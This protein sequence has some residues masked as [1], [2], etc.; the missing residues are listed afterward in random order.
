MVLTVELRE[1]LQLRLNDEPPTENLMEHFGAL[2]KFYDKAEA[3]GKLFIYSER[4]ISRCSAAAVAI[5]M[6]K[7]RSDYA[8]TLALVRSKRPTSLPN[9]NFAHQVCVSHAF[10]TCI[11]FL[12]LLF[13]FLVLND[14][15]SCH[16]FRCVFFVFVWFF[17]CKYG[18]TL[19][20]SPRLQITLQTINATAVR[21]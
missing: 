5:L 4:G 21:R 14:V 8:Q 3:L 20:T 2:F 1:Y 15:V 9:A 7:F 13:P 6:R 16:S 19:R 17:S 10:R 11:L 18:V 12:R